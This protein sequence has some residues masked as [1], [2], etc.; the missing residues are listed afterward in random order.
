MRNLFIL[1]LFLI[2]V[3]NSN[4][5][6][7]KFDVVLEPINIPNLSGLQSYSYGVANGK[8]L[9]LGGR[10]DG[11]HQRQPFSSFSLLGHNENLTVID[12]ISQ[13]FYTVSMSSLS[14]NLREHLRSTNQV[15]IQDGNY[16]YVFGGYGFNTLANDHKTFD[17]LTVIE[18]PGLIN[19][20]INSQPISQFFHQ[21][22]DLRFAVTG[23]RISKIYDT[24]YLVGGH[25]FDGRYNPVGNPT[26]TQAYTNEIR[27]FKISYDGSN[28]VI[29]HLPYINDPVNLHRRDYNAVPQIM[30][31]GKEGMTAFSGV[32]QVNVDLPFLNCV[33]IDSNGYQVNNTFSQYYNHYECAFLPIYSN[34]ENAM[35]TLFF[36][37]IARYYDS[38]GVM[39]TD[40]NVPFVKTIARVTRNSS[41]LM[42]E[43]K[44]PIELPGLLGA[45]AHFIHSENLPI[46]P[47]GVLKIDSLSA[48]TTIVGYIFGG[49]ESTQPN[50]F[51]VNNGTQSSASGQIFRVKLVKNPFAAVHEANY[52]SVSGLQMQIY[53]N[54][55]AENAKVSI[56]LNE[57]SA[58]LINLF[59][60]NGKLIKSYQ[61]ILNKG[62]QTIELENLTNLSSGVYLVQLKTNGFTQTQKMII[63]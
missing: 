16:L 25:K 43:Y 26:F 31:D 4:G 52:Q 61:V 12:P 15:F 21:I 1:L 46:F 9:V 62:E 17:N 47:N 48:D 35:S 13:Q 32:F 53:P 34:S 10:L 55:T 39:I 63:R 49:I 57:N 59:E 33:N 11:L 28:L 27:K 30:P 29:N 44:L 54:P 60:I 37:G 18:V 20:I 5:Q 58:V 23:G 38:V 14:Q 51:F 41:G 50:I 3:T 7:F 45:G 24:F 19:A 42:T 40:D 22:S 8:W 2:F 36:G 6:S 56:Y